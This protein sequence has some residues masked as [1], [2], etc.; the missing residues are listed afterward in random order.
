M[1]E[2]DRVEGIGLKTKELLEKLWSS[3]QASWKVW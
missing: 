2:L 3:G 1:N